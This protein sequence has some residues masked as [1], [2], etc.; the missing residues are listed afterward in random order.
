MVFTHNSYSVKQYVP[1][2]LQILTYTKGY[3]YFSNENITKSNIDYEKTKI[4]KNNI[5]KLKNSSSIDKTFE[6]LES[7]ENFRTLLTYL[8]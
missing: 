7:N 8:L 5:L 1:V 3:Q 2:K 6:K 4:F